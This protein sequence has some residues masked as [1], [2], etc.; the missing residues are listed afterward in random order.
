MAGGTGLRLWRGR[1]GFTLGR[2]SVAPLRVSAPLGVVPLSLGIAALLGV[3]AGRRRVVP[4]RRIVA[5]RGWWVVAGWW[6]AA[7]LRRGITTGVLWIR[8][9]VVAA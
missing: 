6:V 3:I 5:L 8:V 7:A 9:G 4:G 1:G 2:S